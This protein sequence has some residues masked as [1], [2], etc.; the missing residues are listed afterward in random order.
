MIDNPPSASLDSQSQP[1][2]EVQ[3]LKKHFAV[4]KGILFTRTTGHLKAV[5][6]I[7]FAVRRGETM[8][9]VG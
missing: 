6:G 2:L 3:N 4:I 8:G 5:D 7:S 1:I 9:L